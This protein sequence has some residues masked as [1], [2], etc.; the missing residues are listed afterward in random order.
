MLTRSLGCVLIRLVNNMTKLE[1]LVEHKLLIA[2]WLKDYDKTL[3]WYQA[4]ETTRPYEVKVRNEIIEWVA[5][6][7]SDCER[8]ECEIKDEME[9]ITGRKYD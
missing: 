5:E 7:T 8:L 9:K 6:L 1:L 2:K 4:N 3:S